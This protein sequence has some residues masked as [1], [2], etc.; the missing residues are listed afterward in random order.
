VLQASLQD[1]RGNRRRRL[2]RSLVRAGLRR[3]VAVV[4]TLLTILIVVS[5]AVAV[6]QLGEQATREAD[7]RLERHADG[8]A[9]QV[10]ELFASASRDLRLARLNSTFDAALGGASASLPAADRQRVEEGISYVGTRYRVD[11]ICLIRSTGLETARWNGGAVAPVAE[12]SPDESG[13][14][15]FRPAMAYPRDAVF[16]TDPYVSPDSHRWVYGFATPVVLADG[17]RAGVLHFEIPLQRLVDELLADQFGERGFNVL[18]DRADRLLVHPALERYRAEAGLATDPAQAPFPSAATTGTPSWRTVIAAAVSVGS[19]PGVATFEGTNGTYRASYEAVPGT[20]LVAVTVSPTTELYAEVARSRLNLILTAGPMLVLMLV[21]SAWFASRLAGS[22]RRLATASLATSQLASIVESADDAIVSIDPDGRVATWN[23]GARRMYGFTAT[24][25]RGERL[26]ALFAAGKADDLPRLLEAVMAGGRVERHESTHQTAD[27]STFDVWLTLSPIRDRAGTPIGASVIA[28]DI[29]DHKRLE[30]EL[31][32]QALHDSLTGLPNRVLFHDRLRQ[33]LNRLRRPDR[34][35]SG[36][37]A[38]LF[39]DLDDFKIINDTLGHSIGDELLVAVANRLR[40]ALRAVDTAARLGGDEFTILL[41]NIDD[42]R[43]AERAAD[44]ILEELRRPFDLDGHAIVVSASIGIAF[45]DA[46]SNDPDELLRSADTALYEAKGRGKGRHETYHQT[47]NVRAW[48]RLELEAELRLAIAR[49][50]LRVEYQ[51][52]VELETGRVVEAEALVRWQHPVRGLIPPLD[53]IPLAEQTGLI[54]AVGEFVLQTAC[55]DLAR[56][57]RRVPD[58]RELVVSVNASA[59]E[60]VRRGFVDAVTATLE[61]HRL[62]GRRLRL[63][64]TESATIEGAPAIETL[65]ALQAVG[66]RISIDDFGTGYSSL[67]YFR[68]LPIDGLKID[69]AFIDGLVVEREDAAIVTAAIAFGHALDLDVTAEGV[70]TR[71][72][73]ERLRDL[74][75]RYGQGYLFSRPV[76]ASAIPGLIKAAARI[77][78]A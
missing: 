77:D 56:W 14:A 24:E 34:P 15:F 19:E 70:E 74:G 47:M 12:L 17:T 31:A 68:E 73:M 69:R 71:E 16:V 60:L 1:D 33:S 36:R 72:Q 11:E 7:V 40:D 43:D 10:S 4:M 23:D 62:E 49:G 58:A 25:I 78:A 51:P 32:H 21:V 54:T 39:V 55:A 57:Q 44:R 75:C 41:E 29:S 20:N 53:F 5:G 64:I 6:V 61:R 30:G 27:G 37:H 48:R 18:I 35:G 9:R 50:E 66:I 59:R 76:P 22:N 3:P 28:R 8:V 38:V 45:G 26:D 13:N 46:G 2:V 67:A 63:E 65:R 52:I 42:E